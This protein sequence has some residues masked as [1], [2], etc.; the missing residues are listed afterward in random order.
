MLP[1]RGLR[2]SDSRLETGGSG[3]GGALVLSGVN[4]E[5]E[6]DRSGRARGKT[7]QSLVSI[8]ANALYRK[9]LSSCNLPAVESVKNDNA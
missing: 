8:T 7:T 6:R 9:A 5:D 4:G 3:E 1:V 2:W